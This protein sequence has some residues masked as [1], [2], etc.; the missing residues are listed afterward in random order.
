[1]LYS[2][3]SSLSDIEEVTEATKEYDIK[4][5]TLKLMGLLLVKKL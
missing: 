2:V 3:I 1:M 5:A 4:R